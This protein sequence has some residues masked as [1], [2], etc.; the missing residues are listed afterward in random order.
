MEKTVENINEKAIVMLKLI[1]G[2]V[3]MG[4]LKEDTGGYITLKKPMTLML[5]PMQ[6]GVGMIP[7]DAIYTQEECE[8]HSWRADVIM[9]DMPV[10]ESF[11]DAY[12]KQT[13]GIETALPEIEITDDVA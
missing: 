12:I 4:K 8:E 6:G 7:Y 13:T 10:H 1:T 9:H 3:V 5:D 2:E 11:I